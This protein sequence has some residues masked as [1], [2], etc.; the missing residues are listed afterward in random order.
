MKS[1]LR[2]EE[3]EKERKVKVKEALEARAKE[4]EQA[5]AKEEGQ[6]DAVEVEMEPVLGAMVRGGETKKDTDVAREVGGHGFDRLEDFESMP[7]SADADADVGVGSR[8][9]RE[10]MFEGFGLTV[11]TGMGNS[12]SGYSTLAGPA[13]TSSTLPSSTSEYF[14]FDS[15]GAS[16]PSS[17][18]TAT[19]IGASSFDWTS[20]AVDAGRGSKMGMEMEMDGGVGGGGDF[21]SSFTFDCEGLDLSQLVGPSLLMPEALEAEFSAFVAQARD[22][23]RKGSMVGIS[24]GALDAMDGSTHVGPGPVE[25]RT[26]SLFPVSEDVCARLRAEEAITVRF[27]FPISLEFPPFRTLFSMY[28]T[29][30]LFHHSSDITR[31]LGSL[32]FFFCLG[33]WFIGARKRGSPDV[34]RSSG[35]EGPCARASGSCI[36]H[37]LPASEPASARTFGEWIGSS[38]DACPADYDGCFRFAFWSRVWW[39]DDDRPRW[40]RGSGEDDAGER[41]WAWWYGVPVSSRSVAP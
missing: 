20:D 33:C 16:V 15:T 41:V 38:C 10:K 13:S 19:S 3:K 4:E 36:M 1:H 29:P 11:D 32:S 9:A 21:P 6:V 23:G 18:T 30:D 35:S 12:V 26:H 27:L 14:A 34:C 8:N 17:A 37:P 28:T 25:N 31:M 39:W 2:V 5:K 7:M 40:E 22:Q 24:S